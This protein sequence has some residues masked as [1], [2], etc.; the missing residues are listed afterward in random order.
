MWSI[1]RNPTNK[2]KVPKIVVHYFIALLLKNIGDSDWN[3]PLEIPPFLK[4]LLSGEKIENAGIH[5]NKWYCKN[6]IN[7]DQYFIFEDKKYGIFQVIFK[8]KYFI[9]KINFRRVD[10]KS[11]NGFVFNFNGNANTRGITSFNAFIAPKIQ[12]RIAGKIFC[13]ITFT[14]TKGPSGRTST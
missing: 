11:P 14:F 1:D 13:H 9:K 8:N 7:S 2:F 3:N 10:R 4:R 6:I 12:V 5:N